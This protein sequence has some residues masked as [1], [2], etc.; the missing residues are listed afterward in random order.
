MVDEL[1]YYTNVFG[2]HVAMIMRRL[3]RVCAANGSEYPYPFTIRLYELTT[4][5][6]DQEALFVTCSATVND[7]YRVSPQVL[8]RSIALNPNHVAYVGYIRG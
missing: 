8:S 3:R 1:H 4:M 7:P 5:W 6:E 2:S